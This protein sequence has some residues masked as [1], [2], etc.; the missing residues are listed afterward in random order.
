MT[1]SANS[2]LYILTAPSTVAALAAQS[3]N[4]GRSA[5]PDLSPLGGQMMGIQVLPCDSVLSSELIL[6][7]AAQAEDLLVCWRCVRPQ[8][9]T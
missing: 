8:R 7:D 2:K 3:E 5:W 4:S 9:P 1:L 6:L